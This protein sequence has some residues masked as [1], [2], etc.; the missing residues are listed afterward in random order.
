MDVMDEPPLGGQRRP[1]VSAGT[2]LVALRFDTGNMQAAY[3]LWL[4]SGAAHEAFGRWADE[5]GLA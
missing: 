4:N 3:I 5:K 1:R 2:L